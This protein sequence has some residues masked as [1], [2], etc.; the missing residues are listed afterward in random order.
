MRQMARGM[1]VGEETHVM[2]RHV[3]LSTEILACSH[4]SHFC[5]FTETDVI[6]KIVYLSSTR[7]LWQRSHCL[8]ATARSEQAETRSTTCAC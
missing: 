1:R 7:R 3:E 8:A 6:C 4:S 5:S 2:E